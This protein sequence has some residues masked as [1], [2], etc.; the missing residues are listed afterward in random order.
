MV[1]RFPN[2]G[3]GLFYLTVSLC[4]YDSVAYQS[5]LHVSYDLTFAGKRQ[6]RK[7]YVYT[8]KIIPETE[9]YSN[10]LTNILADRI[11]KIL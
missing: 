5:T 2:T 9:S 8:F 10:V 4:N 3:N 7:R 6:R 1:S 11:K